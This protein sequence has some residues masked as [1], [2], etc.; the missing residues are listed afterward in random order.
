MLIR[1]ALYTGLL[2][3][4]WL[5]FLS[6]HA[7]G[8]GV[9][10]PITIP[11][12]LAVPSTSVNES[13]ALVRVR[14]VEDLRKPGSIA[15]VSLPA[16]SN[17]AFIV[18]VKRSVL[19]SELLAAAFG[20]RSHLAAMRSKRSNANIVVYIPATF[21]PRGLSPDDQVKFER[22]VVELRAHPPGDFIEVSG[23]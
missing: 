4:A 19:S 23:L 1:K 14:L 9:T 10:M 7:G 3:V 17:E 12:P 5:P 8:D 6:Q 13:D 16:G 11:R 15:S 22:V 2:S 20:V 18:E 21:S